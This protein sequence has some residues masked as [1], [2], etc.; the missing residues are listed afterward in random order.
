M[1]RTANY[2]FIFKPLSLAI[3]LVSTVCVT[4]CSGGAIHFD[5]GNSAQVSVDENTTGVVWK[6]VALVDAQGSPKGLVYKLSGADAA[7]FSINSASGELAFKQP[8][9]F[10]VPFDSDKDNE[11]VVDIEASYNN[12]YAVQYVH[13]KVKD[14]SKPVITLVK[15]KLNENVGKGDSIEVETVVRFIDAESN[16]PLQGDRVTLNSSPLMQDVGDPQLWKGNIVVPEGGASLYL[17]GILSDNTPLN[18]SAKLFNKRDAISPTYLG[19]NPGQYLFFL[20]PSRYTLGKLNLS[21]GI[22]SEYLQNSVLG[23]LK[24]IYDFN[25]AHQTVYAV[26]TDPASAIDQLFALSV[27]SSFPSVFTAGCLSGVVSITFD[28]TNKRALVVVKSSEQGV[29]RFRVLTFATDQTQGFVKAQTRTGSCSAAA[30]DVVW[31]VPVDIVRGA[32]KQ[33]NFHRLSKTYVVA[34]ERAINGVSKTIIQGFGEDGQKRFEALVGPDISNIAINNT[35]GI[36]Y[37]AENHSSAAGK[38]KTINIATG[39]VGDLVASYGDSAVGAYTDL[40]M[41]NFNKRLYV[42]DDVSDSFFV[43]ELS[44]R[45][46]SELQYKSAIVPSAYD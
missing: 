34:D 17:A 45:I 44:T 25:A 27:G 6:S 36:I 37:V 11:Y 38:I 23:G 13:I 1:N 5:G 10:E 14:V 9:D 26:T 3:V 32:F 20:D 28:G 40:R 35:G 22:W 30:Q 39:E 43:V 31:D 33:F 8:A 19:V 4:A 12:K 46:L 29:D 2:P 15:P 16:T 24:P 42:A 41:D 7:Q 21:N 18:F